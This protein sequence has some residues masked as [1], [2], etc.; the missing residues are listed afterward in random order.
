MMQT[1]P[2]STDRFS[3]L[4][5]RDLLLI[6][7]CSDKGDPDPICSWARELVRLHRAREE[8]P[9][10]ATVCDCRRGEAIRQIT[11]LACAAEPSATVARSIGLLIDRIAAAA[12]RAMRYLAAFGAGSEQMHA[13]WTTLAELELEYSDLISGRFDPRERAPS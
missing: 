9:D 8:F 1:P 4:P 12:E 5:S 2:I 7:V 10:T 3:G 13:A 6:A 11:E